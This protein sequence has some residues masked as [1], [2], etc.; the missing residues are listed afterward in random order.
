MSKQN[1]CLKK[2]Y[3]NRAFFML[4]GAGIILFA[5]LTMFPSVSNSTHAEGDAPDEGISIVVSDSIS[6]DLTLFDE[7]DYGIA[8]DTVSVSSSAAYGYELFLTTDSEA[9]QSIY[10]NDDPTSTSKISPVSDTID[11]PAALTSNTWGFAIAGQGNF[12][13]EYSPTNP[14]PASRFASVP[15]A[16][17]QQ[18][19]FENSNP[20]AYDD[21]DFYFGV[22]VGPT[23]EEGAYKTSIEYT[24]IAKA[25]PRTAKVI[26]GSNKNLNFVYDNNDYMIGNTYTDNLG[27]TTIQGVYPVP[28]SGMECEGPEN[29]LPP[30]LVPAWGQIERNA[31]GSSY[32]PAIS[33]NFDDSFAEAKP[34]NT[35]YWFANQKNLRQLTNLQNLNTSNV[36]NM[37]GMFHSAGYDYYSYSEDT[38]YTFDLRGLDT[39]HVTN[40]QKMFY[41]FGYNAN[42]ATLDIRGWDTSN[43]TNMSHMFY[44][45]FF[46]GINWDIL[47]INDLSVDNVT[48]TKRMFSSVGAGNNDRSNTFA[49]DL[50]NWSTGSITDMSY[51]FYDAGERSVTFSLN[52]SG[53]DTRNVT[54]IT[55]LFNF[56]GHYSTEFE[57]DLSNWKASGMVNFSRMFSNTG[58]NAPLFSLD[59]SN[60]DLNDVT[61]TSSMFAE[62]AEDATTFNLRG[63][64]T[65]KNTNNLQNT[66]FMFTGAGDHAETFSL[67]LSSWNTDSLTNTSYMFSLAGAYSNI[68]DVNLSKWNTSNVT[69]MMYM[70]DS[71]GVNASQFTLNLSS[72]N[73]ENVTDMSCM[74]NESGLRATVWNIGDISG[75][76][77]LKVTNHDGFISMNYPETNAYVVNNPPR[78]ND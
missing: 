9:H 48:T 6:A 56:T 60:W 55:E 14:D 10:L 17:E 30:Y 7:G 50:S 47:G 3:F 12:D 23:I 64:D 66:S 68:F 29:S 41:N 4:S 27:D 75:W 51:M 15:I 26:Y 67:D 59:L 37:S 2:S 76:N 54:N 33:A 18:V 49:L 35:C 39:S 5:F 25:K 1:F 44:N 71:A 28:L 45:T 69:N 63:L 8:K 24:A 20:V 57:L 38:N 40:M 32:G 22:K 65:W 62:I 70:F 77:V 13:N 19:V 16:S 78:W 43:V 21:M 52:L 58:D 74:F 61:S 42:Y 46:Y 72:W 31:W 53:W 36:T 11:E 34:A 73:T